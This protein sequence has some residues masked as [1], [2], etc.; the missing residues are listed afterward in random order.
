[1]SYE[2]IPTDFAARFDKARKRLIMELSL[3]KSMEENAVESELN[4]IFE[5]PTT[6]H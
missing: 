1:M 5:S 3:A 6:A 2:S 4:L